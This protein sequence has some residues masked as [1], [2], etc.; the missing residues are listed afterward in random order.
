M[1]IN[2]EKETLAIR[3]K[4]FT[5]KNFRGWF[6]KNYQPLLPKYHVKNKVFDW[7]AVLSDVQHNGILE[8]FES[9]LIREGKYE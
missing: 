4:T 3:G 7:H 8:I 2:Y 6:A 9:D 5:F 1:K